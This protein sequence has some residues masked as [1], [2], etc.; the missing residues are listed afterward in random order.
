MS[1]NCTFGK[2]A[3]VTRLA[4]KNFL[5]D[6]EAFKINDVV[7][8]GS[9]H[10]PD[11]YKKK[12]DLPDIRPCQRIHLKFGYFSGIIYNFLKSLN[13]EN[14]FFAIKFGLTQPLQHNQEILTVFY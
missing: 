2:R 4:P 11:E 10:G 9:A 3:V 12:L 13:K 6:H 14:A 8:F 5:S 1:M 7:Y